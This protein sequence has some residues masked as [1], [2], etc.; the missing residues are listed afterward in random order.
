M[1]RK[2]ARCDADGVAR[3]RAAAVGAAREARR[4]VMLREAPTAAVRVRV[5]VAVRGR[6]RVRGRVSGA[7]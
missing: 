1:A 3:H 5:R 6:S 4:D 2:V 7:A